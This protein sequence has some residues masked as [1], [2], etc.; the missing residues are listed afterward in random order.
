MENMVYYGSELKVNVGLKPI[1]SFTMDDYDFNCEFYC[2]SNKKLIVNKSKMIKQ[3]ANNY[4]AIVDTKSVGTGS[5]KCKITAYISDGDCEDGL[6]TEVLV[7]DTG[8]SIVK[9]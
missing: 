1:G 7:I 9:G 5:L 8:I 6:R 4:V 3:D 2:Y